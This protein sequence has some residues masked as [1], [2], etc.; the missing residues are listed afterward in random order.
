M[1]QTPRILSVAMAMLLLLVAPGTLADITGLALFGAA[2][3]S[4]RLLARPI[5]RPQRV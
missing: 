5:V 3:A 1:G 2:L 4:Q